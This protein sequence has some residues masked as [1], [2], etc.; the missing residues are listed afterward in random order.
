M[1]GRT[2][3][4][5]HRGETAGG[6]H[7]GLDP[8]RSVPLDQPDRKGAEPGAEG[9]QRPLGPEHHAPAQGWQKA[10][11]TMPGKVHQGAAGLRPP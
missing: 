2:E 10:A 8:E 5:G 3:Q 11:S 1:S 6:G 7:H 9:D 4:R